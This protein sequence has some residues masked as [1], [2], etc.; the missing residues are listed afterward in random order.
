MDK[1]RAPKKLNLEARNLADAWKKWKEELQLYIDLTMDNE[2]DVA[3][4]KMFLYLVGTQ[5]GE[6]FTK[7]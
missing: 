3:M 4:V 7:Q 1:L 5:R 2:N 6:R